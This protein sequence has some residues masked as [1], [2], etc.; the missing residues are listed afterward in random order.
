MKHNL[1]I[2]ERAWKHK[3]KIMESF[4]TLKGEESLRNNSTRIKLNQLNKMIKGNKS[5]ESFR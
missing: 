3:M 2:L 4:K 1:D 5:S